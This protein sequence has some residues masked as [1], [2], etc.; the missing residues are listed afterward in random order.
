MDQIKTFICLVFVFE[1]CTSKLE[2]VNVIIQ[3]PFKHAFK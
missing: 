2:R 1:N 3:H